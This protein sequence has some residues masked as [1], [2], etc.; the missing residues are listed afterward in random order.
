MN[1]K[2]EYVKRLEEA[3]FT[4]KQAEVMVEIMLEIREINFFPNWDLSRISSD[5][6]NDR[7]D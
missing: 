5:K 2:I 1:R 6:R 3:G 4:N 7:K